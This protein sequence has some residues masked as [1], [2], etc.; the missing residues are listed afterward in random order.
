VKEIS[1]WS[2]DS[3]H[4]NQ[5]VQMIKSHKRSVALKESEKAEDHCLKHRSNATGSQGHVAILIS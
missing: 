3:Q 4:V 1:F 2:K 5:V